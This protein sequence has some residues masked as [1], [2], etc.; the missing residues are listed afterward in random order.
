MK[1]TAVTAEE[2]ERGHADAVGD[3]SAASRSSDNP[4]RWAPAIP[5]EP[6]RPSSVP[7]V[8]HQKL[9]ARILSGE[10]ASGHKVRQGDLANAFGTSRVPV[11]EALRR[12]ESEGLVTLRPQRGYVVA[13]LDIKEIE[14]IFQIRIMLEERAGYEATVKRTLEDV[15]ALERILQ[16]MERISVRLGAGLAEWAACNHEFHQRLFSSSGQMHLCRIVNMLRDTVERYI[17]VF[18]AMGRHRDEAQSEHR[19]I[20]VAFRAGDAAEVGRLSREHCQHTCD[21]LT[22]ALRAENARLEQARG[23]I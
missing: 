22:A 19:S 20:L 7:D 2:M 3:A 16:R 12:L 4:M 1:D 13:S 9:R 21:G 6:L 14:E 18:A 10:L 23:E 8:V 5:S 11:R 17:R 15:A